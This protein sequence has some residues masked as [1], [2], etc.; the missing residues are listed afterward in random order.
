MFTA[1]AS[2]AMQCTIRKMTV[3]SVVA[4]M[5]AGSAGAVQG[6]VPTAFPGSTMCS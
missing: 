1:L 4:L 6:P 3:A 5:A 2:S